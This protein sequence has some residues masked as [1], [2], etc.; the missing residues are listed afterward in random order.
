MWKTRAYFFSEVVKY[1]L[2]V[3]AKIGRR[4]TNRVWNLERIKTSATVLIL[5][6]KLKKDED[7][8]SSQEEKTFLYLPHFY[9]RNSSMHHFCFQT[10]S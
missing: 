10:S 6:I 8:I 3:M 5:S 1:V 9:F 2:H 7:E 4:N